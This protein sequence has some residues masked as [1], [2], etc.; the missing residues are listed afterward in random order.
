MALKMSLTRV[1]RAERVLDNAVSFGQ[2][3]SSG[4][5]FLT[6]ALDPFHDT[7]LKDLQGWPD[8][9]TS[10]SVV[11]LIK[12]TASISVPS[13]VT[14]NWDLYVDLWPWLN[15]LPM[16]STAAGGGSRVNNV[17]T[18][19]LSQSALST[20]LG[21]LTFF[22]APAGTPVDYGRTSQ[23]I[24]SLTLDDSFAKGA[25]RIVG[26]GFEVVNTTA[27]IYRQGQALVYRQSNGSNIP[28]DFTTVVLTPAPINAGSVTVCPV[29]CPPNSIADTMLIPGT[30]QWAA[31]EG[32]YIVGAYVGQ[33]NP[34]HMVGYTPPMVYANDANTD[35][36][37]NDPTTA[38]VN[39]SPMLVALPLQNTIGTL[40]TYA[41][42][43]CIV[44]PLHTCGA[45]FTG[46]SPQSSFSISFNI[47]L[48]TFPTPADSQIMVL[49][50]PSA[51]YDPY[52]LEIFSHSMTQLPV[53]VMVRENGLGDWFADAI[54]SAS[55]VF[56]P[57]ADTAGFPLV[58]AGLRAADSAVNAWR[59]SNAPNTKKTRKNDLPRQRKK[60]KQ[61]QQTKPKMPPASRAP[62]NQRRRGRG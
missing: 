58:G 51:Q 19:D 13:T 3:T 29:Q 15:S 20:N 34:P 59:S 40:I 53:G 30:R 44:H 50:T 26:I 23:F 12:Q 60:K 52:A 56:A 42:P 31:A 1:T 37:F 54:Q 21:G 62:R 10:A 55:K 57:V 46:L 27:E 38:L 32:C 47:Y 2:L 41:Q 33:D 45:R 4:K 11:R 14:G 5:D 17:A 43:A 9:E 6:A 49:A 18:I 28:T 24:D 35:T 22:A 36:A 39:N 8:L 48:E 61:P 16:L 7:Q 25:Q